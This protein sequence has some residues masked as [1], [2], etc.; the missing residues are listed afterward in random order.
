MSTKTLFVGLGAAALLFAP[1]FSSASTIS[2]LQAQIASLVAQLKTLE[3]QMGVSDSM[4]GM[5]NGPVGSNSYTGSVDWTN[6][7]YTT[8]SSSTLVPCAAFTRVLALGTQGNDV[9]SLQQYLKSQGYLNASATGYFGTLTAQALGQWQNKNEVVGSN[10]IGYGTFGPMSRSYYTQGCGN[11]NGGGTTTTNQ[12]AFSADPHWGAAPLTVT[13]TTSDSITNSA[14]YS[15]DFGD[16]TNASMSKGSCIG[17]SAIVGGQGGIRCSYTVTHTYTVDGG[18]T[19]KLM[20]NTCPAGAQCFVGPL[21]VATAKV[22]VDSSPTQSKSLSF[23]A[24][25]NS[26]SAPLTVQFIE[27]APQG[28]MI[29]NMVNFGDGTTGTM[30]SAPVC[31]SCNITATVWHTYAQSGTYT[32]MLSNISAQSSGNCA[33]PTNLPCTCPGTSNLATATVTVTG[34]GTTTTSSDQRINAPGNVTLQQGWIAEVRNEGYYFTLTSL[35]SSTATIQVTPVGCWNWFPSDTPP[36]MRCMIAIMPI[37]PITLMVGQTALD[38]RSITLT[39][40]N[41]INATFSVSNN[42]SS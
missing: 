25:P 1:L 11:G 12:Q 17:I 13:F 3:M 8:A 33:C 34:S 5:V 7:G 30:A 39:Q 37:A 32:A 6:S 26:G 9:L 10:G 41:G 21:T 16:G 36:Q 40:I 4:S 23:T 27:T 18:Y 20:K 31:S 15:V 38:G 24:S 29:G 14:T 28:S 19:A 2:D 22:A 35:S 42:P